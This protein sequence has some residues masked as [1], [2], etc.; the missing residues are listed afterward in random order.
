MSENPMVSTRSTL[1]G[2][3]DWGLLATATLR[4]FGPPEPT[5]DLYLS[6]AVQL[7]VFAVALATAL[8]SSV[9]TWQLDPNTA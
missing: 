3:T 8:R 4:P 6:L 9:K 7:I 1:E 2:Y 5:M